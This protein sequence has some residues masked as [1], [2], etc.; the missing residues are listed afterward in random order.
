LMSSTLGSS[1]TKRIYGLDYLGVH[2][3]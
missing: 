1:S 3:D 2:D